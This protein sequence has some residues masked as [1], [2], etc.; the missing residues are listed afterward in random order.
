MSK[1]YPAVEFPVSRG[2]PMI[3]PTIKWD[4]SEDF[5]V[6]QFISH[7]W[8]DKRNVLINVSDKEFEFIQG[9]VID[10]TEIATKTDENFTNYLFD[11]QERIYSLE[12]D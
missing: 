10:G 12:L 4:H 7:D 11:F 3:S 9:H 8:Y 5:F 1:L 2:T 6:P